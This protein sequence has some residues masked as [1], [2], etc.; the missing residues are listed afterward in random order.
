[1]RQDYYGSP[2]VSREEFSLCC[3]PILAH[4]PSLKVLQWAPRVGRDQRDAFEQAARREGWPNYRIVEPDPRGQLVPAQRRDEYFPIWYAASKSGFEAS[5][6][7]GFRGRSGVANGHRQVPRHGP[8]RRQRPDR[9]EQ[10]RTSSPRAANVPARLSG[11]SDGAHRRRPPHASRRP[12]G[13]PVPSRRP[14]GLCGELRERPAG[15]R[16]GAVRRV[17]AGRS[18]AC[19]ISTPR[20]R[21]TNKTARRRA[22]RRCEPAGIHHTEP[23]DVRRTPVVAGLHAR[24]AFLRRP[25][26]LA[27][28][29][30]PGWSD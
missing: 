10:D 22:R 9:S 5:I 18:S 2:S 12:A 30:H 7:L 11:L 14:C 6:R 16:P 3:E 19:S 13:R 15:H 27:V 4:V 29:D 8:I 23:L 28:V 25:C 17:G 20:A 24:P 26:K 1:M 21:G